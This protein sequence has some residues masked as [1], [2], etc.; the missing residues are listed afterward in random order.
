MKKYI[1]IMLALLLTFVAVS[2]SGNV[3]IPADTT[4]AAPQTAPETEPVP[5]TVGLIDENGEA[6]YRIVRPDEG[7]E[8]AIQIGI[9]LKNRLRL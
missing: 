3:D 5:T 4:D 8:G 7:S 1:T 2:C 6:L 9:D